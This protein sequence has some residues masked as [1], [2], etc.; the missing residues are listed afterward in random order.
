METSGL[1]WIAIIRQVVEKV[2][3]HIQ[4]R[5]CPPIKIIHNT[6]GS[7]A[8]CTEYLVFCPT[9]TTDSHL[10]QRQIQTIITL[11]ITMRYLYSAPYN[12]GQRLWSRK[13]LIELNKKCNAKCNYCARGCERGPPPSPFPCPTA[14]PHPSLCSC[15]SV[16]PN[17]CWNQITGVKSTV[18]Y[19][20]CTK[21][22][23]GHQK[24][25]LH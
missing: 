10:S 12:I 3:H 16:V 2:L 7:R 13:K 15:S 21:A 1:L 25:L 19:R 17:H 24:L 20:Q 23:P 4:L 6:S 11:T 9:D 5:F 22:E 18:N 8:I 14:P